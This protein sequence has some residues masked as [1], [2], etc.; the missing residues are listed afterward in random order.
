MLA[1]YFSYFSFGIT[2]WLHPIQC[3]NNFKLRQS[4]HFCWCNRHDKANVSFL[5]YFADPRN[6]GLVIQIR[7]W[8]LVSCTKVIA[9]IGSIVGID[10][11]IF[12][13]YESCWSILKYTK[14]VATYSRVGLLLCDF[15][16]SSVPPA[17]IAMEAEVLQEHTNALARIERSPSAGARG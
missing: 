13:R 12:M 1:M 3:F 2:I 17:R 8:N 9:W 11:R 10:L 16:C 7:I 4:R 5:F 15:L 6:P 14:A